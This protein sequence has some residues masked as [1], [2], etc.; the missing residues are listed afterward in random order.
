ME[1]EQL[2]VFVDKSGH[3]FEVF[4]GDGEDDYNDRVG[5]LMRGG[6]KFTA[7]DMFVFKQDLIDAGFEWGRDFYVKKA[8]FTKPKE[9]KDG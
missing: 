5:A 7:G 1:P 2:Y 4:Q 6:E 9:G 8:G 3:C